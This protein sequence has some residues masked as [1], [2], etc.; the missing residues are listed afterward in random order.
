MQLWNE[1]RK[2][3][4]AEKWKNYVKHTNKII[5]DGWER[6]RLIDASDIIPLIINVDESDDDFSQVVIYHYL[7]IVF[8]QQ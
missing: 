4:T 6:E 8:L 3:V 1:A 5:N 2:N 7:F